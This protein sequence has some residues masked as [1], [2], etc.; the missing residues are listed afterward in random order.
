LRDR[1]RSGIVPPMNTLQEIKAA[2][3]KL[4][5]EERSELAGW[6]LQETMEYREQEELQREIQLGLDDIARG[7]VAPLDIEATIREAREEW[8]RERGS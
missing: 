6:L 3:A 4:P 1:V 8:L 2:A 5:V 7:D